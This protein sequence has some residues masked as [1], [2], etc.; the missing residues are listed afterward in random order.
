MERPP[1]SPDKTRERRT[2]ASMLAAAPMAA[3]SGN[4]LTEVCYDGMQRFLHTG[5]ENEDRIRRHLSVCALQLHSRSTWRREGGRDGLRTSPA[6]GASSAS[7]DYGAAGD[8]HVE[9]ALADRRAGSIRGGEAV[10]WRHHETAGPD[11]CSQ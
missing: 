7:S 6:A 1:C 11:I 4:P 10:N 2:S 5:L 3:D 8:L 9:A